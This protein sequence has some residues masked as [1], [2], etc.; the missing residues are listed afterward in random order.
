MSKMLPAVRGQF[1]KF[2]NRAYLCL[3]SKPHQKKV[4][5][6][7]SCLRTNQLAVHNNFH[8]LPQL[9]SVPAF[10]IVSLRLMSPFLPICNW[11]IIDK[12]QWVKNHP[13]CNNCDILASG[14]AE[15]ICKEMKRLLVS[16]INSPHWPDKND[17]QDNVWLFPIP[18]LAH[19]LWVG[20]VK[21]IG[22]KQLNSSLVENITTHL[23]SHNVTATT[24]TR[25]NVLC[26]H[27][28]WPK[29]SQ[30]ENL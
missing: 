12:V 16:K 7:A 11:C 8:I 24:A 23:Y 15:G 21:V 13:A 19:F 3:N 2:W 5:S 30:R 4:T 26:P 29:T 10:W 20:E 28:A 22:C 25:G 14:K 9:A 18:T 17:L 27:K 1:T 6:M